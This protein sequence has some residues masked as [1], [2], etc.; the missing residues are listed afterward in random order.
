MAKYYKWAAI[1]SKD[2]R[3]S[4]DQMA[5]LQ[6]QALRDIVA[7]DLRSVRELAGKTQGEVAEALNTVQSGISRIEA[8]ADVKLSTLRSYV[9]ALGGRLDVIATIGNKSVRL[10]SV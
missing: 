6:R 4:R 2:G 10:Q 7:C 8:R 9:E 1:K 5:K 3:I